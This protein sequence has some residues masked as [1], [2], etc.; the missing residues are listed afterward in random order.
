MNSILSASG[1]LQRSRGSRIISKAQMETPV[2]LVEGMLEHRILQKRWHS[3]GT[4]DRTNIEIE[5]PEEGAGKTAVIEEYIHRRGN[6]NVFA[7]VDMDYDFSRQLLPDDPNIFDT[8][9]LVTLPSHAIK[10]SKS[11][12][13]ALM[14]LSSGIYLL[15]E[16]SKQILRVARALTIV[17]LFKGSE[18]TKTTFGNLNWMEIDFS[19][20]KE[21]E[22][23]AHIFKMELGEQHVASVQAFVKHHRHQLNRC[24]INDHM[25]FHA[26]SLCYE[27]HFPDVS[28]KV[29][30]SFEKGFFEPFIIDAIGR[31]KNDIVDQIRSAILS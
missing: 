23:N 10:S 6:G 13:S 18:G 28:P 4:G 19:F 16:N 31:Q 22:F 29:L 2:I 12:K 1:D 27:G 25:M 17:K 8:A 15:E 3:P 24:G 11:Q 14:T 9:P 20:E 30:R 7:L 21:E 5:F 26:W